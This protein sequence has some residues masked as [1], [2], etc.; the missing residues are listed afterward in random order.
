MIL[1]ASAISAFKRC[2]KS[3][4]LGWEYMLEPNETT[5]AINKG[6]AFHAAMEAAAKG[7]PMP[8]SDMQDVVDAYLKNVGLPENILHA[9]TPLFTKVGNDTI[10]W[11]PDLIYKDRNFLCMRDY[12]TFSRRPSGNVDHMF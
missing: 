9:E 12:K 3:Y 7:L 2:R 5:E 10:R 1:S 4:Q 8:K 11:T 6:S